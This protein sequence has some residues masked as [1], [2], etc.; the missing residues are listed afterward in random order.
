[1]K[2]LNALRQIEGTV[3]AVVGVGRMPWVRGVVAGSG[4]VVMEISL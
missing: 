4:A 3:C 1:M 2:T